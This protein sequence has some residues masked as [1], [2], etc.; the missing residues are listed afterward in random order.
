MQYGMAFDDQ[1]RADDLIVDHDGV[2]I[3]VD[4]FSVSYLQG[5]EMCIRDSLDTVVIDDQVVGSSLV[6]EGHPVLHSRASAAAD[7]HPQREGRV[8]LLG[9]QLLQAGLG[10][11]G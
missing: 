7:E 6:V 2:Q 3:L 11:R 5:S 1:R 4:D 10:Y 8:V 9:E